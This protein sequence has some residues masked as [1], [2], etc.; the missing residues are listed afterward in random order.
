MNK[1][2]S[3]TLVPP[4]GRIKA[5]RMPVWAVAVLLIMAGAGIAGYFVPVD[6]LIVT[7]QELEHTKNLSEQNRRLHQ[8]IGATLKMLNGLKEHTSSLEAAKARTNEVIG[9]P[10]ASAPPQKQDKQVAVSAE[11]LRRIDEQEKFIAAFAAAAAE[12]NSSGQNL[13]DTIPALHPVSGSNSVI[14]RRFGMSRDPFTGKNKTH[15]GTDFAAAIGVPVVASASGTVTLVENHP[16]WG[17]RVT[18]THGRRLRTVYAHLGT[19]SVTQGRQ[20][21]RGEALGTMGLSGLTTGPHVHYELW[22]GNEQINPEEYLFP[23]A[24]TKKD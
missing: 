15:Y 6:K 8:N 16:E 19:V 20:I 12:Q 13:F 22:R 14:T 4:H 7:S 24:L 5:L 11:F 21:K 23:D 2:P 17:R 18:I 10:Q 9:L 1:K 3:I